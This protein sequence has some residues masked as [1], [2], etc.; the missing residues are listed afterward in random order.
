VNLKQLSRTHADY[1]AA[2]LKRHSDLFAGGEQFAK[3][4][5][6]YLYQNDREPL[7]VYKKR[8]GVAGD[9]YVNYCAPIVNYFSSWLM[10]S[11]LAFRTDPEQVDEF[12]D[13]F[14]EDCDDQG[15]D[16]TN[17][18]KH[19][20]VEAL[21][22]GTAF[23]RVEFPSPP[24]PGAEPQ[25]LSDWKKS[26]LGRAIIVRVPT[27][28][29]TN[30]MRDQYGYVWLCEH[31]KE[32]AL[33]DPSDDEET[34]TA[35]WTFWRRDGEHRRYQ[36]EYP[37]S[38]PPLPTN[39]IPEVDL[40]NNWGQIVGIP[41]V[42]LELP[43]ELWVMN[44]ISGPQLEN[45]R[46]RVGLS[47]AIDRTCYAMPVFSMKDRK[48]PPTM[49]AG[50]YIT[51]GLDDKASYLSP[52]ANTFDIV[53]AYAEDLKDEIHRVTNQMARG[54]DNNA[55]SVGRSGTSKDIDDR[56]TEIVLSGFGIHVRH[57][58]ENTLDLIAQGRGADAD[59]GF[60]V[61][62]LDNYH[63]TDA[64]T[65]VTMLGT[66]STA[67]VPPIQS[68]THQREMQ[69]MASRVLLPALDEPRRADIEAEI[70]KSVT[71][72][73]IAG[74]AAPPPDPEDQKDRLV[75]RAVKA[76]QA[77]LISAQTASKQL[78]PVFGHDSKAEPAKIEKE[79]ADNMS[80]DYGPMLGKGAPP[81]PNEETEK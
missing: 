77:D 34:V 36:V 18:A 5:S 57:A 19:A 63:V 76:H 73:S 20:F 25:V 67:G 26:G 64:A 51:I 38:R 23:W 32:S 55:A 66:L 29:V 44:L 2:L 70:D 22:S 50:Y 3:N 40:E 58:I 4:V 14:K 16:L 42:Q 35:T 31:A 65:F 56:Q 12:Y 79:K 46:K 39:T 28:N 81:A 75:D 72:K 68:V 24:P 74:D 53:K 33:V 27:E 13:E 41:V 45:W 47:W 61:T 43:R 1:D 52:P 60:H 15:S 9:A 69:K 80:A 10:T 6:D 59:I 62:G 78:E 30:W 54:V 17:F 71:D 37:A 7:A 49:G 21:K 48:K 11:E 8:C